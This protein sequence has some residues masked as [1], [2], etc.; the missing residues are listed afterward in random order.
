MSVEV[1]NVGPVSPVPRCLSLASKTVLSADL[2]ALSQQ[3]AA[4]DVLGIEPNHPE[5][6]SGLAVQQ[7]AGPDKYTK[8]FRGV[9]IS[10]ECRVVS[11][12]DD[13]GTTVVRSTAVADLR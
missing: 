6:V 9:F 2:D 3:R 11:G 13:E 8:I 1:E 10:F 4:R 7:L 12:F 5:H